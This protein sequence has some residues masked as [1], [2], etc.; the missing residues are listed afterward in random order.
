[1]SKKI[2]LDKSEKAVCIRIAVDA[3]KTQKEAEELCACFS[4]SKPLYEEDTTV[5]S[6]NANRAVNTTISRKGMIPEGKRTD[7]KDD[8]IEVSKI[9]IEDRVK[10]GDTLEEARQKSIGIKRFMY[11][12]A[13]GCHI[14]YSHDAQGR[15]EFDSSNAP[16][17]PVETTEEKLWREV[18]TLRR[19]FG[20]SEDEAREHAYYILGDFPEDYHRGTRELQTDKAAKL[21][22]DILKD[23]NY[24]EVLTW[25]MAVWELAHKEA[26]IKQLNEKQK[27]DHDHNLKDS[28]VGDLYGKTKEQTIKE[29]AANPLF[30]EFEETV[31][32]RGV[33]MID[34]NMGFPTENRLT[35]GSLYGKTKK[36]IEEMDK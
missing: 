7:P 10:L 22:E 20:D 32:A 3:G 28:T 13:E 16:A 17:K 14:Y 36:E 18:K 2:G 33:H 23:A 5:R 8:P 31:K 4:A 9:F 24:Y 25:D 21:K 11:D 6:I 30:N 1:M 29:D 19:N 26:E 12:D 15:I 34:G 35:V 27:Y